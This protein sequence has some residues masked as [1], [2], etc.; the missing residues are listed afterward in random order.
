MLLRRMP[1]WADWGVL[2]YHR[3]LLR[4]YYKA[5]GFLFSEDHIVPL[6]HPLV[7][8]FHC[9]ANIQ[10]IPLEDNLRKSNLWWP[11]MPE[12]QMELI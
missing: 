6:H 1:A 3:K 2:M 4:I 8:G 7:C 9:E 5:T 11:D 12:E 10:F